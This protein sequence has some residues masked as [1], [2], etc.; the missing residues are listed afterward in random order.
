MLY[1][2]IAALVTVLAGLVLLTACGSGG[3]SGTASSGGP[4][5]G[6]ATLV[7]D[8]PTT[9]SDGSPLNYA[10]DLQSYKLYYGTSSHAYSHSIAVGNPGTTPVSY[11]ANLPQGT[12]YF[13]VTDIDQY[14]QE[15]ALSPEVSKVL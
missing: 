7:W 4:P 8:A 13:A 11:T 3:S 9:R 15:S 2:V 1:R 10:T 5:T 12:Y 6:A 14:G